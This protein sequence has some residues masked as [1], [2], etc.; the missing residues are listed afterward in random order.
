MNKEIILGHLNQMLNGH[1]TW[2][3]LYVD[4]VCKVPYLMSVCLERSSALSIGDC[5]L[6]A[7][8]KAA[9]LAV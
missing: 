7:V 9:R 2:K 1:L 8:R 6:P 3:K 4:P 5:I